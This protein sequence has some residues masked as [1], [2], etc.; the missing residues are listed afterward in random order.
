MNTYIADPSQFS[1]GRYQS[2]LAD[3]CIRLRCALLEIVTSPSLPS[4][5]HGPGPYF[6]SWHEGREPH[7]FRVDFTPATGLPTLL[8]SHGLET[9]P[10]IA[11]IQCCI[12]TYQLM[13]LPLEADANEYLL[14]AS[15]EA[16]NSK[17]AFNG[18][19]QVPCPDDPNRTRSLTADV[20]LKFR[21]L[22]NQDLFQELTWECITRILNIEVQM[23][24]GTNG[25][26][27]AA[28][29]Y[30][31]RWLRLGDPMLDLGYRGWPTLKT[32]DYATGR[33][34]ST[35]RRVGESQV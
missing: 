11:R 7:C 32:R 31:R 15:M 18:F 29:E 10:G 2:S 33:E 9:I 13:D 1:W 5:R 34:I 17:G 22:K 24:T 20:A 6:E 4:A 14:T 25:L 12:A 3:P 27:V 23:R 26:Y 35:F 30:H 21:F 19:V 8:S 28:D 16:F